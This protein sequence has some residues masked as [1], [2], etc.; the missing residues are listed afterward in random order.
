MWK[1]NSLCWVTFK[2]HNSFGICNHVINTDIQ[3]NHFDWNSIAVQPVVTC[4]E[5]LGMRSLKYFLIIFSPFF[6]PTFG[7][8]PIFLKVSTHR[9]DPISRTCIF[10]SRK[11]SGHP[12]YEKCQYDNYTFYNSHFVFL[13]I[14]EFEGAKTRL[15]FIG[16]KPKW[17]LIPFLETINFVFLTIIWFLQELKKSFK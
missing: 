7:S 1:Q 16:I 17:L 4:G 15:N 3:C 9:F 10:T 6:V 11:D 8:D 12:W 2:N 13:S 14:N 5:I